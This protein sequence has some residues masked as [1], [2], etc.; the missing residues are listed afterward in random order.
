MP[1]SI[2]V[3]ALRR[4]L[5]RTPCRDLHT[6]REMLQVQELL[7]SDECLALIRASVL[8][9]ESPLRAIAPILDE[10]LTKLSRRLDR[11]GAY[12][13]P[14]RWRVNQALSE[15]LT[16]LCDVIGLEPR[17]DRRSNIRHK[18]YGRGV[19]YQEIADA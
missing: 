4:R 17:N 3:A 8:F 19:V 2:N 15:L 13:D 14:A 6:E 12:K 18:N 5:A 16:E 11:R 7:L 1:E 9:E 10:P